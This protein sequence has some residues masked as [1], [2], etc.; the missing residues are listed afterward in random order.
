MLEKIFEA[1]CE[2]ET[3]P[4]PIELVEPDHQ[5][6]VAA[7]IQKQ[8]EIIYEAIKA[9]DG[10]FAYFYMKEHLTFMYRIY[11]EYFQ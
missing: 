9:R 11:D 8:H 1:L 3:P 7:K 10:E 2:Q 4:N 5:K 6:T